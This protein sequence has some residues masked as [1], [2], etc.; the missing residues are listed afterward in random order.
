MSERE[1]QLLEE[2]IEQVKIAYPWLLNNIKRIQEG[3]YSDELKHA[4]SVGELLEAL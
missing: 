3:N 2:V 1:K 4:I